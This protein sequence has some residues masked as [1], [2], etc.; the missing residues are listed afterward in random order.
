M[1]RR[2]ILC[3]F[4]LLYTVSYVAAARTPL[5]PEVSAA[6]ATSN[7]TTKAAW[8][9]VLAASLLASNEGCSLALPSHVDLLRYT[10]TDTL[11]GGS[12]LC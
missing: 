12:I 7:A 4:V 3:C 11:A 1:A 5:S 2:S 9:S 8:A 10:G 6:L